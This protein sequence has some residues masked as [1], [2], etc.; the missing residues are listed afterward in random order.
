MVFEISASLPLLIL[1]FWMTLAP[2]TGIV[3]LLLMVL[4]FNLSSAMP[5]SP[6]LVWMPTPELLLTW[7]LVSVGIALPAKP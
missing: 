4:F 1:M 3:E 2:L 6:P 7:L 5:S